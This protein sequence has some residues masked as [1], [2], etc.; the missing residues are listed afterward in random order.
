LG[1]R[2]LSQLCGESQQAWQE[3]TESAIAALQARERLWDGV[4]SAIEA[5]V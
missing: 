5:G 4:L 2:M 3:A 1:M